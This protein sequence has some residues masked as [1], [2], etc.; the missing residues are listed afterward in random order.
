VP[1]RTFSL[2]LNCLI[3]LNSIV[4]R[5]APSN[6]ISCL[7]FSL[8]QISFDQ[9]SVKYLVKYGSKSRSEKGHEKVSV[10]GSRQKKETGQ[11][12]EKTGPNMTEH[13]IPF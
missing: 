3:S 1:K 11:K 8:G 9:F 13:E 6:S 12:L 5:I 10:E 2:L 4:D 7:G